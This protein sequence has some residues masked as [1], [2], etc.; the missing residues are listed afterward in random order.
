MDFVTDTSS[1]SSVAVEQKSCAIGPTLLTASAVTQYTVP[2][3]RTFRLEGISIANYNAS[4]RTVTIYVVASGGSAADANSIINAF[5]IPGNDV[6]VWDGVIA[7]MK[8][9]ETLQALASNTNSLI[10]KGYGVEF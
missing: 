7:I 3:R 6:L 2:S 9:G 5:S 1:S 8:T 4:A 10:F